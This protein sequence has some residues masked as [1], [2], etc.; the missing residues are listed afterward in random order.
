MQDKNFLCDYLH[1]YFDS[2]EPK[3]FYRNI[4]PVGELEEEGKQQ[5]GKYNAIAVELLP[6]VEDR[7]NVKRFI[8]NDSMNIMDKLLECVI[9]ESIYEELENIIKNY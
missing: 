7:S 3:E 6:Q 5:Q 1:Q 8:I 4:F 9:E 2:I